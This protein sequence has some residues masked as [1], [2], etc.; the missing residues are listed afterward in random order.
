MPLFVFVLTNIIIGQVLTECNIYLVRVLIFSTQLE[1]C[2]Q[3]LYNHPMIDNIK[4][5]IANVSQELFNSYGYQKVSMR[6]IADACD[7]SVGNLTYHYP[8]K[9][10][11]LML[12][13][14]AILNDF[15]SDVL[16]DN[17]ELSGLQ[18]YFTVECAF[19]HMILNQ[20]QIARLYSQVI[21]V[22]SLRRRYCCAHHELFCRFT[23]CEDDSGTEWKATVAMC[24]LEFEFA[25]EGIL[26]EN[27]ADSM[28][29]IFRAR[30]LFAGR[31]PKDC[32]AEISAGIAA[33]IKLSESRR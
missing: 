26:L 10:D 23:G 7:I 28:A 32:E 4:E 3:M 18:G 31:D 9:E 27:F 13:H 16:G 17:S 11:L 30:R 33:G 20:P 22:P 25:D 24:A 6:Q 5:K 1:I 29:D 12:E 21:N 8:L 15:L 19:L 14:D 2:F